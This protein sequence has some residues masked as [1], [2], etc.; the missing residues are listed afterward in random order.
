MSAAGAPA[1]PHL[2][3]ESVRRDFPM[4]AQTMRGKPLAFL[5]SAASAQK[6]QRVIDA[7]SQFY[8]GG[9]ANIHRGLY[10]LSAQATREFE[11]VRDKVQQFIG[12]A[13]RREIIFVRSATEAINLVAHSWGRSHLSAGDEIL[14]TGMEH[15]SN[16]VPWQILCREKGAILRVVPLDDRGDLEPGGFENELSPR[17]RLVSL[18]H[19]SNALGTINP[20]RELAALARARGI[21]VL[22]D[23]AQAVPHMP[24]D[25][26][27][28]GCDFYVFSGHK[29]FGPTGA[30]VLY[31]RLPLL[32]AM[33][34][35]M[36]GGEMIESVSF[37][38][39][40]Y[41]AVPYKFEAGT[42]DI[43]SVIGLGAA[44]DY[45]QELGMERIGAWERALA[46]YANEALAAIPEL[47]IL[48]TARCK[49][50]LLS[51]VIEGIHPHDIATVLDGEGIAVRAGHHCAQPVME[52]YGVPATT[53]ASLSFYNTR[54]EVDRLVLAI[55]KALELFG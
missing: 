10:Q 21:P 2:D 33:P 17:T 41:A 54:E 36:G 37:E 50:A 6:P 45:V 14:I 5:D 26:Q 44:I 43:A 15:H 35:F 28:L 19:V 25:V 39:T 47:R 34:P 27:A 7:I 20:V 49:C 4:L 42:P 3:V 1:V 53:R 9:Y 22:L 55:R 16:I 48:G 51:F 18:C 52:R 30:G 23:G 31:G 32:E 13:D 29:L 12:A 46:D 8:S 24:V 11:A 40:T 38:Q